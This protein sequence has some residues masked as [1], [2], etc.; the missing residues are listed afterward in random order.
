MLFDWQ[1]A[2]KDI[3]MAEGKRGLP[4]L[5]SLFVLM[6][7][8]VLP[9]NL[10]V[11]DNPVETPLESTE[12]LN[13]LARFQMT[14][15]GEANILSARATEDAPLYGTPCATAT[16][17]QPIPNTALIDYIETGLDENGIEY[18]RV[19]A[20][21]YRGSTCVLVAPER[22]LHQDLTIHLQSDNENLDEV[23]IL[24]II[25]ASLVSA[26]DI[27]MTF[28]TR[29][30]IQFEDSIWQTSNFPVVRQAYLEGIDIETIYQQNL[31]D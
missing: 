20:L 25:L 17:P 14:Q 16:Q 21:R 6:A 8:S 26:Q 24:D 31:Y 2:K 27:D 29:V 5:L 30:T 4:F 11:T 18:Q 1:R 28:L 3:D 23:A 12:E 7:C 22:K 15:T 9:Q 19:D 10:T 13:D